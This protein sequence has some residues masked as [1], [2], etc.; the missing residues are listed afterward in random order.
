[1]SGS[2][3]AYSEAVPYLNTPMKPNPGIHVSK[4][5]HSPI[6]SWPLGVRSSCMNLA[7]H[8]T[9]CSTELKHSVTGCTYIS[10]VTPM[11]WKVMPGRSFWSCFNVSWGCKKNE[12][13]LKRSLVLRTKAAGCSFKIYLLQPL[14][15]QSHCNLLMYAF[16]LLS[17][18]NI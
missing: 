14:L 18:R 17:K 9:F 8:E 16:Y 1:M 12:I 10:L 3:Q 15:C 2:P 6:L 11:H 5:T 7:V 13:Y 4:S